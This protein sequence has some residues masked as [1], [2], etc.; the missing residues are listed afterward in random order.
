MA[1]QYISEDLK[2]FIKE[3]IQTVFRLEVLL[4]L[5]REHGRSFTASDVALELGFEKD[6]AQ[7]QLASL[8]SLELILQSN[9]DEAKYIYQP[10]NVRSE[11]MVNELAIAYSKRRIPILSMLLN[12]C[13][14]R[15]R[16]FAEAFRIIKGKD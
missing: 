10:A 11:Y 9:T 14:G 7:A 4:L 2:A 6:V 13:A 3:K 15:P 5:H 12:D 8:T 1:K 16:V